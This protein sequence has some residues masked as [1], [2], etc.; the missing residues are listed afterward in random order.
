MTQVL[1]SYDKYLEDLQE[2]ERRFPSSGFG[3]LSDIRESA[4]A[5][6]DK[7]GLPTRTQGN[8]DWKYTNIRSLASTAFQYVFE[9]NFERVTEAQLKELAP[10]DDSWASLVFVDGHYVEA[11]S[12]A[13]PRADGAHIG[14]LT[15]AIVTHKDIAERHLAKYALAEADGFSAM[16]TAFLHDGAFVYVPKDCAV[17]RPLHIIFV[18]A[19]DAQPTVSHPRALIV[20]E[21][22]SSITIV[23]SY[24][25]VSSVPYLTNSVTEIVLGDGASAKH[26]KLLM[27]NADAFHVGTTQVYQGKDSAFR[28]VS[29]VK[30]SAIARNNVSVLLDNPGGNCFLRGLYLTSGKEHI[31]NHIDIDHAKPHATSDLYFKGILSGRSKA[32][33]SGRV[34]V[35]KDAQKSSAIQRDKNL[36]MSKGAEVDSSPSLEI[37]ADDVQCT[38]GA[39]AGAVAEDALFYMM[40]RGIDKETATLFLIQGFAREIVDEIQLTTL[41]DYVET[42]ISGALPNLRSGQEL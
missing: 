23:E 24:L 1:T 37:Y 7:L 18:A 38:H 11:L 9:P 14:S 4:I 40:S 28:S 34:L 12:T 29:F 3:R 22:N 15:D 25:G 30:G 26:Y 6:F 10:W 17:E 31:D 20:L 2:F 41:R 42:R 13:S 36:L 8:E 27:E 39:T 21:E 19:G 5:S 35:Q 16:N 32:V 33:F